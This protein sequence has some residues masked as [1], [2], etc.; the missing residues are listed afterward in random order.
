MIGKISNGTFTVLS[1]LTDQSSSHLLGLV[2]L[3]SI[4]DVFQTA[5]CESIWQNNHMDFTFITEH[6]RIGNSLN[7]V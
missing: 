2:W 6:Q 7:L 4:Q 5:G 3:R 1:G